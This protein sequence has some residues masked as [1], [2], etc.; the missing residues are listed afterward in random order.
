VDKEAI[1]RIATSEV[2]DQFCSD[3][4]RFDHFSL[5]SSL[6]NAMA[7]SFKEQPL[8]FI[9]HWECSHRHFRPVSLAYT[10]V[11]FAQRRGKVVDWILVHHRL[12]GEV[13]EL[14][15]LVLFRDLLE[16]VYVDLPHPVFTDALAYQG[17]FSRSY[18]WVMD[19]LKDP[20]ILLQEPR[21]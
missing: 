4:R 1:A 19:F 6:H 15:R 13:T 18:E 16:E 9:R 21:V 8:P 10:L 11:D 20:E 17:K 14:N 12:A 7:G 3:Y 5:T 2:A